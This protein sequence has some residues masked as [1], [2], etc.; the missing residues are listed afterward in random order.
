MNLLRTPRESIELQEEACAVSLPVKR[1]PP[2]AG[3]ENGKKLR[4]RY[5]R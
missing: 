1:A 2:V 4:V 5:L 3:G